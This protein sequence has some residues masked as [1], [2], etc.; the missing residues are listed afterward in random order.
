M[1]DLR[2]TKYDLMVM[3]TMLQFVL[4]S[5]VLVYVPVWANLLLADFVESRK[6][7]VPEPVQGRV[8]PSG[9]TPDCVRAGVEYDN[10][11]PPTFT[12]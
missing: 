9:A 3:K 10:T 5:F 12:L 6:G 7:R 2:V 11:L 1:F 4:G 8:E